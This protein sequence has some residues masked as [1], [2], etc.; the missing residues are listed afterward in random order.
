MWGL[1][2]LVDEKGKPWLCEVN[3]NP[4]LEISSSLLS[5]IIPEL[6]DNTFRL[7]NDV[8]LPS[9]KIP[10]YAQHFITHNKY[11]LLH[12]SEGK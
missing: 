4:S 6:L 11:S 1:D 8:L 5:R 3:N 10:E 7:V 9:K 2:Y 12:R